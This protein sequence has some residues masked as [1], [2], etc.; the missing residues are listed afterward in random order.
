MVHGD[1]HRCSPG[2]YGGEV[3]RFGDNSRRRGQHLAGLAA[4]ALVTAACTGGDGSDPV[5]SI[6][7]TT[8]LPPETRVD[9][10]VLHLGALIPASDTAVGPAL[11]RSVEA[12]VQAINDAGGVLGNR[13]RLTIDDE[14]ATAVSTAEAIERLVAAGVDAIIGP[15]SSNSAIGALDGAVAAG[16][17]TCS[18]TATAI[19][20]DDFPDDGFFFRSIAT[21]SLQ[22]TAIALEAQQTG[23]TQIAVVHVDDAY[24]RPYAEATINA[25]D[26]ES[27]IEVETIS[28]PVN[29]DDLTDDVDALAA[30]SAQVAIILG[31]GD[32]TA[33][34]L[35]ALGQHEAT[36]ITEIIVNDAARNASAQVF[37]SLPADLRSIIIGVAPQIVLPESAGVDDNS[38]FAPQVTDCVNLIGLA[39]VQSHSDSPNLIAGQMASV[40]SG[41]SVCMTFAECAERIEQELQINYNGP[42]GIT[43]LGR[44]GD[45]TRARFDTFSFI[46]DGSNVYDRSFTAER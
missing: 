42:T 15:T 5:S 41:G 27:T 8:T 24:G 43:E 26:D 32:D 13:V 30:S 10:G 4:I 36:A 1:L 38:A 40:S 16:I 12:A 39:A 25:L 22:A 35:E 45:P 23:A 14:G 3:R 37:A 28:I 34:F 31:S 21:D 44:D 6:A 11:T 46:A 17:V 19:A 7:T 29:D 2:R 9:D 18:A 33:R 20:L